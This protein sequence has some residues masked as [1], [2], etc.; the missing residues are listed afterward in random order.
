MNEYKCIDVRPFGANI[1]AEIK[2]IDITSPLKKET[3]REIKAAWQTYLVLL[4]RDQNLEPQ[5]HMSFAQYFG[6]P[7][8]A[9][10]V[11]T[12]KEFPFIRHQ[13]LNKNPE[14]KISKIGGANL[15]WHHDDSFW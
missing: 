2:G 4:F 3:I 12:L 1:G 7:Q 5:Q 8:K 6:E 14:K 13:E 11:P 9:G 10:F 15:I